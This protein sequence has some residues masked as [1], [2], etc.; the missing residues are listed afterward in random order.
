MAFRKASSAG[1]GLAGSRLSSISPRTRCS[2]A[3]NARKPSAVARRQRF[4][5]DGDGAVG[6]ARPGFSLGQ[7]NLQQPVEKQNVLFAQQ[8]DA[9]AHVLEPV[10]GRAGA[11]RSPNPA[12][13]TPNAPH[14]VQV[15][16]ARE[17][18]EFEGVRRGARVVAAHQFE[19][20][21][22]HPSQRE[23][24][25]MGEGRDPRLHAV[26]ERNRAI[27]LAERP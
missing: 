20:G 23:R 3:S 11:R 17:A 27:D 26:D 22:V 24:A 4:V 12:R 18:G 19:H 9:A 7:R 21:R 1:A 2:S 15:M 16:L 10:A 8:F 14:M 25:D 13:N 6:I 5:E